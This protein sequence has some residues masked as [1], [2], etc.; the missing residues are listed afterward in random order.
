MPPELLEQEMVFSNNST[1]LNNMLTLCQDKCFTTETT[2][3]KSQ[4]LCIDRC[5]KKFFKVAEEFEVLSKDKVEQM[6]GRF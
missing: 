5:L 3:T 6:G 1:R 2:L 4:N